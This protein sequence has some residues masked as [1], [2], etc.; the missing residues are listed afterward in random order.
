MR[1]LPKN[2]RTLIQIKG[3]FY[4]LEE[5]AYHMERYP[6]VREEIARVYGVKFV[7]GYE[8][9]KA[10]LTTISTNA[11]EQLPMFE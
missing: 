7:V 9:S 8:H 4:T 2:H 1:K 6:C 10:T 5:L 11:T 3:M